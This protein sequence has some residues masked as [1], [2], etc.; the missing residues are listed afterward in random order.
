[1]DNTMPI[2][3]WKFI[4]KGDTE[5]STTEKEEWCWIADYTDGTSLKQFDDE[6]YFHYFSEID[7]SRL[8]T[9]RMVHEQLPQVVVAFRPG[10]KLIHFHKVTVRTASEKAPELRVRVPCFGYEGIG[11][12]KTDIIKVIL[13]IMPDGSIIVLDDA[14]K[15]TFNMEG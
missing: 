8:Y 3:T 6:G 2:P 11:E 15:L 9:F 10:F 13:A 5:E 1:M 4:P 7:Q 12:N 14:N